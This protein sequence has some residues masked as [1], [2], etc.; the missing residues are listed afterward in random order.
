MRRTR[1]L[2]SALWVMAVLSGLF[3]GTAHAAIKSVGTSGGTPTLAEDCLF[4]SL[5]SVTTP[6]AAHIV[7]GSCDNIGAPGSKLLKFTAWGAQCYVDSAA[8]AASAGGG[9]STVA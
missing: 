7:S 9:I 4:N 8:A 5:L 3:A 2:Q 6:A 1:A